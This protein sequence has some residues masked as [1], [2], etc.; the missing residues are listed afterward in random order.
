[1]RAAQDTGRAVRRRQLEGH[2][3]HRQVLYPSLDPRAHLPG[4]GGRAQDIGE[5][6]RRHPGQEGDDRLHPDSAG[7]YEILLAGGAV[8][9]APT[10]DRPRDQDV[11]SVHRH[12]RVD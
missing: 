10:Q 3:G 1:M 2:Q 8:L 11:H 7:D 12:Q 5:G 9:R 6:E 4:C